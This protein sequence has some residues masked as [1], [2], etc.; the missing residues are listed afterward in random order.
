MELKGELFKELIK[1]GPSIEGG[2][3]IWNI[4]KRDFLFGTPELAKGFLK[5][6]THKRYE[7]IVVQKEIEM[8][9]KHKE[10]IF[11]E[12][13]NGN[14]NLIDLGCGN[15]TKAK[16][17]LSSFSNIKSMIRYAPVNVDQ[18]LVNLA[19]ENVKN[20]GFLHVKEFSPLLSGFESL[21]EVVT[22]LR[23]S[24]YPRNIV[25]LLGSILAN[26]DIHNYLFNLSN[27][28]FEGDVLLI[29]NGI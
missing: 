11:N 12:L 17:L 16:S 5:L 23:S 6:R 22:N 18:Y 9:G 25:L 21:D 28:M 27:A 7:E 10:V 1:Q 14:F 19:L 2:R 20:E 3:R 29:G 13:N 8:L 26:F 24:N 4:A 15:G